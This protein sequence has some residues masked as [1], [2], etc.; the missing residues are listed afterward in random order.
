MLSVQ[1]Y[2]YNVKCIIEYDGSRYGGFQIQPNTDTIEA[3]LIEVLSLITK[4]NVKIY[5]SGRTDKGVHAKGQVI[6]FYTN[7]NIP[8]D[9]FKYAINNQLPLDIRVTNLEYVDMSFHARFS[10]I[11]K[12]YR[13]YVKQE[14]LNAFEHN[15]IVSLKKIDLNLVKNGLKL[16]EGRHNFKGFCSMDVDK[17]KDFVKTIYEASVIENGTTLEFKFVGTGFLKY[18]IRR[19]MAVLIAIGLHEE[20]ISIITKILE[21]KDPCLYTKVAEPNG[22]YLTKVYY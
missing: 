21:T 9:K 15:Y 5:G 8:C 18:Q 12:E 11:K 16:L 19:M 17:R 20:D 3:H 7:V 6:N 1:E 22:L 10:A 13:Y 4:E 2:T 14:P